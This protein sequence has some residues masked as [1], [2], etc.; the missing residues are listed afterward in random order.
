MMKARKVLS[1]ALSA[2]MATGLLA[3]CTSSAET[4]PQTTVE[5]WDSYDTVYIGYPKMQY[6]FLS[7]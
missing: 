3:G 4:T 1:L 2:V 7:V 5:N 6:G